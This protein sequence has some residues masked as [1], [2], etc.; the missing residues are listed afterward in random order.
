[1]G[2]TQTV[3][4]IPMPDSEAAAAVVDGQNPA[5][6][7]SLT[8]RQALAACAFPALGLAFTTLFPGCTR[9]TGPAE[10]PDLMWGRRG[11]SEGR[12]LKPRAIAIDPDDQLYIVDTTAEFKFLMRTEITSAA[13][14]HPKRSSA[15]PRV[16]RSIKKVSYWSPTRTTI[17]S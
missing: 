13:G 4:A 7:S 2:Q 16:W 8:R 10:E 17:A 15:D 12:F 14:R 1:M 5:N 11:L 3:T 6:R 9:S